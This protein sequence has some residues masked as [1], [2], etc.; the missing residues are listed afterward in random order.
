MKGGHRFLV[1]VLW[2]LWPPFA[3]ADAA[4]W[5]SAFDLGA[6]TY[7]L[8]DQTP[9]IHLRRAL[10]DAE[11]LDGPRLA[12]T[13]NALALALRRANFGSSLEVRRQGEAE[14]E[15]LY[16]RAMAILG[17]ADSRLLAT[18]CLNLADLYDSDSLKRYAEAE[19]LFLR[20]VSM[21]ERI[22]GAADPNTAAALEPLSQHYQA[23][24]RLKEAESLHLRV[25]SIYENALGR[26]HWRIIQPVDRLMHLYAYRT[27]QFSEAD[28]TYHRFADL[29]R[30]NPALRRQTV[31][32]AF[33]GV[34]D[35]F[36]T[37]RSD[38][39][40]AEALYKEAVEIAEKSA[41]YR[42]LLPDAYQRLAALYAHQWRYA[43]AE[44]LLEKSLSIKGDLRQSDIT[45]E[46][47]MLAD[48]RLILGRHSEVEVIYRQALSRIQEYGWDNPGMVSAW[49][50]LGGLYS[51]LSRYQEAEVA[52]QRALEVV[53]RNDE[54]V[55]QGGRPDA[56]MTEDRGT[57]SA[58]LGHVYSQQGRMQE[59]EKLYREAHSV[60]ARHF[61]RDHPL[62]WSTAVSLGDHLRAA[63][64]T[65]EARA[66]YEQA[67]A[68]REKLHGA[69]HRGLVAPLYGLAFTQGRESRL[70]EAVS[71]ARRASHLLGSATSAGLG[72]ETMRSYEPLLAEHIGLLHEYGRNM[73]NAG[74]AAMR[75]AFEIAQLAKASAT[76]QEVLRMAA[77]QA[78]GK[79][80]L[81][82]VVRE[83]ERAAQRIELL[84][85][86][87]F[88]SLSAA[89]SRDAGSEERLRSEQRAERERLA[90]LDE[91]ITRRFPEYRELTNPRP[92][93][94]EQAQALLAGDEALVA[95]F[96]GKGAAYVWAVGRTKS[97]F[98][99]LPID[100]ATLDGLVKR[101]RAGLDLGDE[102]VMT[103]SFD[104]AAA[105]ELYRNLIEPIQLVLEGVRH[106]ILVPDGS[107]QSLPFGVL[108]YED[109]AGS[110]PTLG[111]LYRGSANRNLQVVPQA[112]GS[113]A[114]AQEAK[115]YGE[116]P[117]LLRRYATTVLP[118]V[119]SLRALRAFAKAEA[120]AEPFVG[121][122]DPVLTGPPTQARKSSLTALFRRGTVADVKQVRELER[123]P[124]TADELKAI[125]RTLN[126]PDE[127]LYLRE[128]A[129][130]AR[131]KALDLTR[132]RHLVFATHGLLA[133]D[134]K[135]VAEP[136]LVLTPP[137]EGSEEDDGLLTASEVAQLKL[138]SDWVIL[139]ACNTAAADGTPGAEGLSGLAKAFFYAGARALLVSHWA[140]SSEAAVALTTR[141]F[142]QSARGAGRAQALQSAMLSFL[143]QAENPHFAHP[144]M[145]APFVVVGEGNAGWRPSR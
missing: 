35:Y 13:A 107:L 84:R 129:T 46:L 34:A 16:R 44:L 93:A 36:R 25:I 99:Q 60:L 130:E 74:P 56:A 12:L 1:V 82:A 112:T 17:E 124:D 73:S 4:S 68:G 78:A 110:L 52:F 111:E 100:A 38:F 122:G 137:Q 37:E 5:K 85:Q 109:H 55:I 15:A 48:L 23:R 33:L 28:R 126:A 26:D 2:L 66:F 94:V 7:D 54:R 67:L 6:R 19:A 119:T 14:A 134:I 29:H 71:N 83:R 22:F 77:R 97:A 143:R 144:A 106:L 95:F 30:K 118:A 61:G 53:E 116:L 92:L 27:R 69:Q 51:N 40:A 142:E 65:G 145:W 103:R 58:E 87:I 63:G 131:L 75:E 121:F 102:R 132:F 98:Q 108:L 88:K 42:S 123:L 11:Q 64:K 81:S 91:D 128:R 101:V 138:N 113:H 72:A 43:E 114:A 8:G 115:R 47:L 86:Q 49:S 18:V 89:G 127:A 24:G 59:A 76:A 117:W 9:V 90:A 31:I 140:V 125:A 104:S 32:R 21:R 3:W 41:E 20:A 79:T 10:K 80:E 139:S 62:V 141:T 70:S 45:A 57:L 136:A 133:G 96:V 39:A 120:A 50:R 105:R 135:G